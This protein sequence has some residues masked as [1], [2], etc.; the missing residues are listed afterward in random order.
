MEKKKKKKTIPPHKLFRF[1]TATDW[2]L[3][4]VAIL[5]SCASGAVLPV[6][7]IVF[8]QYLR[9]VA[10]SLE[11]INTMLDNVLPLIYVMAY[12]GMGLFI[13]GYL[14]QTCWIISGESQTRR[15]RFKYLHS[16]LRQDIAWFDKAEQGSLTTRLTSDMQLIQD[17]ISE[18]LGLVIVCFA[19]LLTGFI[20]AL[21]VNWKLALVTL[22]ATPMTIVAAVI[23][24]V[25]V[26]KY[27]QQSQDAYAFAGAIAEQAFS[28]IRTVF[29]F[30]MQS[31]FLQRYNDR[32]VAARNNGYKRGLAFGVGIGVQIMFF[33]GV[34]GLAFWYGSRLVFDGS[35]DG[36]TIVVVL[37]CIMIG[38]S[39][40]MT[41]AS[42]LN[43]VI[44]ACA[45]ATSV[46]A[47]IDR[48]PE[49]DPDAN[50]DVTIKQLQ[51]DIE[52]K[53]VEFQY[54]S[55]PDLTIFKDFGLSI[56]HGQTVALVGASGSGKSTTAQLLQRFY[57]VTKGQILLDGQDIQSLHLG[58]LREQIGVVSQE[59]V[60]FNLSIRQNILL[61]STTPV[62]EQQ[63]IDTCK[64]AN[65]HEFISALSHGYDT[66]VGENATMLSGGQKQR[67]AIARA[68]LK[69]PAILLL[70]E[71]TSALDTRSERIVQAAL[72]AASV[73]RTT[74][75]IAHRLSTIQNADK[76]VVMQ[77]GDIVEQGTHAELLAL[78]GAYKSLVD[79][80][81]IGEQGSATDVKRSDQVES[82]PSQTTVD[83]PCSLTNDEKFNVDMEKKAAQLNDAALTGYDL[84]RQ[85]QKE[86]A[87]TLGTER[88]P[89]MRLFKECKDEK[90]LLLAGFFGAALYGVPYA[91]FGY[92]FGQAVVQL[93]IDVNPNIG[94]FEGVN[95]Y[96]FLYLIVGII[97]LL[98]SILKYTCFEIAGE[99]Y[100]KKLRYKLFNAYLKQEVA[101]YD[102]PQ[103]STGA[104]TAKLATD[105]KLINDMIT[106]ALG[107]IIQILALAV[108]GMTMAFYFCWQLGLVALCMSPF[109][110]AGGY[111]DSTLE[112]GFSND[113]KDAYAN[114]GEIAS[115]A[116]RGI[117]TVASLN[118]QAYFEAQF[119]QATEQSHKLTLRKACLTSI[120]Y[121]VYQ[122]NYVFNEAVC[123]YAGTHFVINGWT[124]FND[125]FNA[126]MIMALAFSGLG[127]SI[128][129]LKTFARSKV[130]A[131]SIFNILD[132]K[133][134]ID[135]DLEG[136]EP[137]G[138]SGQVDFTDVA[139]HYPSR[140][141]IPIFRGNFDL[142]C[143]PGKTVAL[144]GHS[145]NGKS[146]VISMLERWY[147]PQAGKVAVDGYKVETMTLG[148][149]R[150]QM[151]LV[152]Q[153]PVLFDL[154]IKENIML[155]SDTDLDLDDI[156]LAC[157]Q[158]NIYNFVESLADGF[159]TLVGERGSQL[160][161]GQKQRIAIA[162][163]LVRKPKILLLDEA[164]SALD[165]ES[166]K[167]VQEAL[168]QV[169]ENGDRTTITIAHR[170]STI[171]NADLICV[172]DGGKIQEQGTHAELLAF[173]GLY[174]ELVRQQMLEIA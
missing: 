112:Y 42:H 53:H 141:D 117:R 75:V 12:M 79:K 19:Q 71:A 172:I 52:F 159:D 129:Q 61:G 164:T 26:S 161:G 166:E 23:M 9:T 17:G 46:F 154:S 66:I 158:A 57:D 65:C 45:A 72:D 69:N 28:G 39:G 34:Y 48:V 133:P 38:S 62:T 157:Q 6:S 114:A 60:L 87:K 44:N 116:I 16:V 142:H 18:K 147:D 165:S 83:N 88:A 50:K 143:L 124:T 131:I 77:Q 1:A 151:A 31:S 111:V 58:W 92:F 99:K 2:L 14:A 56:R 135:P 81:Q 21:V 132:R 97:I 85:R 137:K 13:S 36:P 127:T 118:Q 119:R 8:G 74:I 146:T 78:N 24:G 5:A 89:L 32:L 102:E 54:P 55:R 4:T 35:L 98:V 104:L 173:G 122:S 134:R 93:T 138:L 3:I 96:A 51:G 170:L 91:I 125:F 156:K 43:A 113:T 63:I 86:E 160:S 107:E 15:I 80:Q 163:A 167:L 68:I 20:T 64:I 37:E 150:S 168:D 115:E 59:P 130:A 73:N 33:F 174:A 148:Y 108:V 103:H 145:G 128:P 76:I 7:A 70:D 106:K 136:V 22:A 155:G 84:E 30:N 67:I 95:L 109:I 144:V 123:L 49:I 101:Y 162:R 10:T 121:A 40:I 120:G 100:T 152:G 140:P 25:Y 27:T 41:V 47:V 169:I 153:E 149:L 90:W 94:P 110:L 82:N 105:C 29:A 171:K 139:F 126:L 11:N